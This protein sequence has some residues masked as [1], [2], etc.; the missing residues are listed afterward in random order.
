MLTILVISIIGISFY[1][2]QSTDTVSINGNLVS[3]SVVDTE[4]QRM[5]GLSG[6]EKLDP[7]NGM[8]F[9]FDTNDFHGIWMKDM[10]FPIDILWLDEA[11]R[12]VS[13]KAS[14]SPDSYPEV[15]RPSAAAKYVIE[16][17]KGSLSQYNVSIGQTVE[18]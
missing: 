16:L 9:I 12:V 11:K 10:N 8:L 3:V 2:E 18:L 7:G 14:A 6:K 5:K 15:F 13:V 17:P 1:L 4:D